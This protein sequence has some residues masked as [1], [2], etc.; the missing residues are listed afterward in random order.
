MTYITR[1][2]SIKALDLSV[3]SYN[4]LRRAGIDTIEKLLACSEEELRK[5]RNL[6]AKSVEEIQSVIVGLQDGCGALRLA[7]AEEAAALRAADVSSPEIAVDTSSGALYEDAPIESLSLSVRA[8]HSLKSFGIKNI[9]QLIGLDRDEL[10]RIRNM[11][12]KSVEET[13][14]ALENYK[15]AHPVTSL[16]EQANAD[17]AAE[18]SSNAQPDPDAA[19]I[20]AFAE[21][22]LF[23]TSETRQQIATVR[24]L[25]PLA[26]EEMLLS[27][28]FEQE[29]VRDR[30]KEVI[31]QH[32]EEADAPVGLD[33]L[34]KLLPDGAEDTA[35]LDSLLSEMEQETTVYRKGSTLRRRWPSVK[36]YVAGLDNERAREIISARLEGKSLVE[37]GEPFRLSRERVRQIV[38][39]YLLRGRPRLEEDKYALFFS[40]YFVSREEFCRIFDEPAATFQYLGMVCDRV[41]AEPFS[42]SLRDSDI[43]AEI[44]QRVLD[45]IQKEYIVISGSSVKK[46]KT[47]EKHTE[48]LKKLLVRGGLV[49]LPTTS[50]L[51]KSIAAFCDKNDL[52]TEAYLKALGFERTMEKPGPDEIAPAGDD[53]AEDSAFSPEQLTDRLRGIYPDRVIYR[54][55]FTIGIVGEPLMHQLSYFAEEAGQTSVQW[56]A[57][58][59]FDWRETGY[60]EDDMRPQEHELE[61]GDAFSIADHVFRTYPL[62]GQFIP[63]REQQTTVFEYSQSVFRKLMNSGSRVSPEEEAVLILSTVELLKDWTTDTQTENGDTSLWH[64]IYLQ[65]GFH[66]ESAEG[67]E[68]RIYQRFCKAIRN[69]LERYHRFI[70]PSGTMV[71]YTSLLLH[72]LAPQKSIDNLLNIL[73]DFYVKNLDFQYVPEDTSYKAFVRGMQARWDGDS[74]TELQLRSDSLMSGL[75]V[76]FQARPGYMAVLCDDL[77]RKM[78]LLLRG[79][80]L[81]PQDRW[82][83]LLLDWYR[84]K[85]SAA[86]SAMQGSRRERRIEYVATSAERIYLQ[87][88]LQNEL[89]GLQ[90]PRI[91]LQETGETRPELILYQDEREIYRKTLSVTGNDL[92]LTTRSLFVPLE[93]TGMDPSDRLNI[94]CRIEYLGSTLYDSGKKLHRSHVVFDQ[95]GTERSVRSGTIYLFTDDSR[96]VSPEDGDGVYRV[97]THPGQ[98]LRLN[99]SEVG[100]VAVDGTEIFTNEQYAG[101]LR[102]YP[103]ARPIQGMS[104]CDQGIRYQIFGGPFSVS[105]RIPEGEN[106]KQYLLLLDDVQLP[107]PEAEDRE[108]S[109]ELP[110][111]TARRH[112]LSVADIV[113]ERIA[114]ELRYVILDAFSWRLDKALYLET[115]DRAE[116]TICIG[117][118]E[119]RVPAQRS[120]GSDT[121]VALSPFGG[122]DYEVELPT[123]HCSFGGRSAF[124]LPKRMWW[125]SVGKEVFCRLSLPAG[126]TGSMMLRTRELPENKDGVIELGNLLR[127][128]LAHQTEEPLL[129]FMRAQDG[130]I[131]I[132]IPT[133][134]VFNPMF[135]GEPVKKCEG[136]LTWS[137]A[138]D[139]IGPANA[140]FRLELRSKKASRTILLGESDGPLPGTDELPNGRYTYKVFLRPRGLFS[141]EEPLLYA[142][143]CVVG[144]ENKFRFEGKELRL[145]S[146]ICWN[147][148]SEELETVELREN[149]GI[150]EDMIFQGITRPYAD[151]E[152]ILLPEYEATLCYEKKDGS[153]KAFGSDEASDEY[154][155]INPVKVWVVS[156]TRLIVRTPLNELVYLDKAKH[157]IL[158]HDPDRILS[159]AEQRKRLR[160]PDY[161]DC[162]TEEA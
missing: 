59:G 121:A 147:G 77:V 136:M 42:L 109:V 117:D 28:L 92:C 63:T 126:W 57:D 69:T 27:L 148:L 4:A 38:G 70:S 115:E 25:R 84:R 83:E 9:S 7:D 95:N 41:S 32:L 68:Q 46:T 29:T 151:D 137:P 99:L 107:L 138:A 6:G 104:V 62:A 128:G 154:E 111:E 131:A 34:Y 146:A 33:E 73:F 67:T 61:G 159:R 12:A 162:V 112:R 145:Q 3:R 74:S 11:G 82:D 149:A 72:A 98:L 152:T 96:N 90:A 110:G 124:A 86:R 23:S 91:R 158:S 71:Y 89:V 20:L 155:W 97:A 100:F 48:E 10:G 64:Y 153:R 21:K 87:Y 24:E 127:S 44:Q 103:K 150:L 26:G 51:Y 8:N 5:M 88:V 116:L 123:V 144:D 129:L 102:I 49:Y 52:E 156:E 113:N 39:K 18:S 14:A 2:D 161:F 60:T 114:A 47:M 36:E 122:A 134:I 135:L 94:R 133:T 43:S 35:I 125:E 78:D 54:D 81:I 45:H 119:V 142:G 141:R 132:E 101:L 37:A 108:Y 15:A 1:E 85:S 19:L 17:C 140:Q 31:L 106:P 160:N 55:S 76:L 105:I 143:S 58:H 13:L 93:Q 139:F 56:L 16:S 118:S 30:V 50:L 157:T 53:T 75:R 66:P 80:T 40:R 120:V 79:E 130:E 65:F 22:K